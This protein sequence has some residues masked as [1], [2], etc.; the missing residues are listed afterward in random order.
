[1]AGGVRVLITFWMVK[2]VTRE[3]GPMMAKI[4]H[5]VTLTSVRLRLKN[6][7]N[8]GWYENSTFWASSAKKVLLTAE[9]VGGPKLTKFNME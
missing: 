4:Q 5:G 3:G 9:K 6:G 8:S 7:Q 2:S 1:M